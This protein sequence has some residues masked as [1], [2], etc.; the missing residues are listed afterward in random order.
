[1]PKGSSAQHF[2]RILSENTDAYYSNKVD[3]DTFHEMQRQTWD[4][5]QKAGPR[6]NSE[7]LRLLRER[8]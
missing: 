7:V 1:M 2:V 6:V 3:Y 8:R 5:I 4:K